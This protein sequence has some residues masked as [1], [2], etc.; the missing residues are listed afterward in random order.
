MTVIQQSLSLSLPPTTATSNSNSRGGLPLCNFLRRG[1][2]HHYCLIIIVLCL[3]NLHNTPLCQL[4]SS[5]PSLIAYASANNDNNANMAA[6]ATASATATDGTYSP[7]HFY[8]G[9]NWSI[10]AAQ[11]DAFRSHPRQTPA[12]RYSHASVFDPPR[13]R[14]LIFQGYYYDH[15]AGVPRWCADT[16]AFDIDTRTWSLAHDGKG[17]NENEGQ[18][19]SPTGGGGGGGDG[20]DGRGGTASLMAPLARYGHTA[21]SALHP[22]PSS[23]S[24]PP[25]PPPPRPSPS[26]P[27]PLSPLTVSS[28]STSPSTKATSTHQSIKNKKQPENHVVYV[29]GGNV[30]EEMAQQP[31]DI[32][33]RS[34]MNDLWRYDCAHDAWE[35]LGESVR[36]RAD[37]IRWHR[38]RQGLR[39]NKKN[40]AVKKNVNKRLAA[41]SSSDGVF[42]ERDLEWPPPRSLHASGVVMGPHSGK[43]GTMVIHG[44][45]MLG[46]TWLLDLSTL[47]WRMWHQQQQQQDQQQ[48]GGGHGDGDGGHGDGDGGGSDGG[49]GGSGGPVDPGVRHGAAYAAYEDAFYVIGGSVLESPP[50]PAT[51]TPTTTTSRLLNDVWC[52]RVTSGWQLLQPSQPRVPQAQTTASSS[53][54]AA[55]TPAPSPALWSDI[56]RPWPRGRSYASATALRPPTSA[57]AAESGDG[58]GPLLLLFAGANCTGS[59]TLYSDTWVYNVQDAAWTEVIPALTGSMPSTRYRGTLTA[60]PNTDYAVAFGGES[61]RPR[62]MYHNGVDRIHLREHVVRGVHG[63]GRGRDRDHGDEGADSYGA[64]HSW[65]RRVGKGSDLSLIASYSLLLLLLLLLLLVISCSLAAMRK[66]SQG[67]TDGRKG[68]L[69]GQI[70][71]PLGGLKAD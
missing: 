55:T 4:L 8:Y 36:Q 18:K 37:E 11:D 49:G 34:L 12:F 27:S 24:P 19:T 1:Y 25:P 62:Y 17:G 26:P 29:F 51:T 46:D 7:P 32:P 58:G 15:K 70:R 47:K 64:S 57:A 43:A 33:Q 30:G 52:F 14:L 40:A 31:S 23:S 9:A 35:Q 5:S 56:M 59:C 48:R 44:G 61:Y 67:P 3:S 71:R 2:L 41:V 63:R 13:N 50:S 38:L 22:S 69:G 53:A 28:T 45:L 66:R 65:W 68:F 10:L 54:A 6:T 60:I 39:M 42:V 20:R 21:V 16:W